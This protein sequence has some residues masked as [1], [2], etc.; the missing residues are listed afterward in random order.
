M[1]ISKEKCQATNWFNPYTCEK[2][3]ITVG[4]KNRK[5]YY[6]PA[7]LKFTGAGVYLIKTKVGGKW[8]I[9]YVGMSASDVKKTLYRHFQTWTDRRSKWNE[10][11]KVWDR[12]TYA[13]DFSNADFLV[14]IIKTPT[15]DEAR[16][17]EEALIKKLKPRDNRAKLSLYTEKQYKKMEE[18]YEE[19]ETIKPDYSTIE[20][21]F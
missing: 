21:P 7:T 2:I 10:T 14:K 13:T 4:K 6:A 20:V 17:L 19:A 11:K 18:K 8:K 16:I 12:V 5:A 9:V 15:G 3:L 1:N